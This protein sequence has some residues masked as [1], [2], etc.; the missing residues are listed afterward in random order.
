M[1]QTEALHQPH[2]MHNTGYNTELS[3]QLSLAGDYFVEVVA[4]LHLLLEFW[5]DL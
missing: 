4:P 5:L 2:Q 3:I 1:F